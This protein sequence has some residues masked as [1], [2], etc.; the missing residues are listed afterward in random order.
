[1]YPVIDLGDQVPELPEQLGNKEKYWFRLED[2]RYLFK[3]GRP[4]TGENWAEK[5]A[6]ELADA[7]GLPHADYDFAI[8][9][10]RK[11][12]WTPSME[13][14]DAR[15]I[16]G[17]ELLASIH[18]GYPRHEIRRVREHTLGRIHALLSRTKITAPLDWPSPTAGIVT[19]YDVFVGYLLFDA[20]IA[21]QD[22]HHENWVNRSRLLT[23][24]A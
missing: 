8:W 13:P 9:G 14:E 12:V 5:I 1:M 18:T 19:A 4:G 17:N 11:G 16:L 7:L 10:G 15:L 23:H 21:N 24:K 22:R 20:W 6:A 2:R 3:I